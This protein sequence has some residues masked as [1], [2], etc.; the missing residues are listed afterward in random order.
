MTERPAAGDRRILSDE[1]AA[2]LRAYAAGQRER[3]DRLAA[4][5]EDIALNGLPRP[6]DCTPWEAIRDRRLAELAAGSDRAAAERHH[7]A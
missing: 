2:A 6:E 1:S 4:V 3:A 5:L 7:A